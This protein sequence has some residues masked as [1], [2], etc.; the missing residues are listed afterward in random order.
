MS[1]STYVKTN[2]EGSVEQYPYSLAQLQNAYPN[3]SFPDPMPDS[4][5]AE[6]DVFPVEDTPAPTYNPMT[7]NISLID[8]IYTNNRWVQQWSVT[9]ATPQQ[10]AER[11][12][13]YR[14]SL[15]CSPLQ[16]KIQ[17]NDDGLLED[18]EAAVAAADI[19]TRLA[20]VNAVIWLR[21]SPLIETMGAGLG[22]SPTQLDDL[23][24][25]AQTIVV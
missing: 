25:N 13:R 1:Y 4:T 8:P 24:E 23:F 7:E 20:W 22:L 2:G 10:Q 21:T 3:V 14:Q 6:Y 17:L 12:A 18:A 16:G 9:Q 11:L 15:S 5:A 19:N